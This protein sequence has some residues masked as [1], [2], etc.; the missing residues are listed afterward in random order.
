MSL[1]VMSAYVAFNGFPGQDVQDPIGSVLLQERQ[2]SVDVPSVSID[3]PTRS[4]SQTLDGRRHR[5][6]AGQRAGGP[7]ATADGPVNHRLS[8][9][10]PASTQTPATGT[11]TVQAPSTPQLP[12]TPPSVPQVSLP[13]VEVPG[14]QTPTQVQLPVDTG[15]VTNTVTNLLSG[16]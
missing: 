2:A 1:F 11:N 9:Q 5:H 16:K 10:A 6:A 14:V 12:A 8:T 15:G 13:Q 7:K 4:A 3:A